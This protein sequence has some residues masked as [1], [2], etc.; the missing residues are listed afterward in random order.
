MEYEK[1]SQFCSITSFMRLD[2][3]KDAG[4]VQVKQSVTVR[5]PR[6]SKSSWRMMMVR[7]S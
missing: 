2:D 5:I 1:V 3:G 6:H 4:E 7:S